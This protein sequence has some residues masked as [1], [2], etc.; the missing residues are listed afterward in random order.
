[1][2]WM[3]GILVYI[4]IWWL[5]LFVTLPFGISPQENPEPGTVPSAPAKPRLGLKAG[6]TTVA[7]AVLW[8]IFYYVVQ[9]DLI[10]FRPK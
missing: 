5:V 10:S 8:G 4:I 1:M 9:A 3:T 2:S 6:I 7:A